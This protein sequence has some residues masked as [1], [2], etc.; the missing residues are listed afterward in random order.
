MGANSLLHSVVYYSLHPPTAPSE[1]VTVKNPRR[2]LYWNL[3]NIVDLHRGRCRHIRYMW[4]HS[5]E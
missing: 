5:R 2:T 4:R 3:V 1:H